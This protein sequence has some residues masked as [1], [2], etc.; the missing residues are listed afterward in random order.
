MS[1]Y[2]GWTNYATW[3]V[4]LEILADIEFDHKVT[5]DDLEEIVEECVFRNPNTCD[6]PYLVE[7]YARCFL[8]DVN[9]EEIAEAINE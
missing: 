8:S 6:T 7:D 5:A 1:T 2:N 4:N 9:Y 3:K